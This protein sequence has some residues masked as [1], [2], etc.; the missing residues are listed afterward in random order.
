M[1]CLFNTIPY[2][3][4]MLLIKNGKLNMDK[5]IT[6]ESSLLGL[7]LQLGYTSDA[8]IYIFLQSRV[9]KTLSKMVCRDNRGENSHQSGV[10]DAALGKDICQK[11]SWRNN[12]T[13]CILSKSDTIMEKNRK[14]LICIVI[15]SS[16]VTGLKTLLSMI[17]RIFWISSS[18]PNIR[19]FC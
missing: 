18:L 6:N 14:V 3:V 9:R 4:L 2:C 7:M 17:T 8:L 13:N 12:T 10:W 16:N 11:A 1:V 19:G 15:K 5:H